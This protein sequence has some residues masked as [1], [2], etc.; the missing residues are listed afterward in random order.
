MF[1][2]QPYS[3]DHPIHISGEMLQNETDLRQNKLDN[4]T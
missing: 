1:N 4:S 2:S 3:E